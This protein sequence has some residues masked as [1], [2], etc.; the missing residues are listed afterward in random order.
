MAI[1]NSKCDRASLW[2]IIIIII[3]IIINIIIISFILFIIIA[4]ILLSLMSL[5]VANDSFIIY[6]HQESYR[7]LQT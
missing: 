7:C 4:I 1:M 2:I 6:M 3:I 5:T